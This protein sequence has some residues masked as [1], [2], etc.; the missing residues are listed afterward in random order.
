MPDVA[1]V[2]PHAQRLLHVAHVDA[3]AAGGE[4]VDLH[5]EVLHAVVAEREHVGGAR[6][7]AHHLLHLARDAVQF[8][9]AEAEGLHHHVAA[10]ADD[11][12]LHP[13]VDRL[14]DRVG[15]A[16]EGVQDLADLVDDEV[17]VALVPPLLARRDGQEEVAVVQPDGVDA[18]FVGAGAAHDAAHLGHRLQDLAL[19]DHVGFGRLLD[20]DGGVLAE[21]HHRGALV[22]RRHE[23]GA[24]AGV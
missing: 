18:E 9:D 21:R 4:A 1:P 7:A 15:D 2:H 3:E 14:V 23:G 5:L 19:Q 17:R 22:H 12:F 6:H 16:R 11:H 24:D 8:R 10:G 13:H 20:T